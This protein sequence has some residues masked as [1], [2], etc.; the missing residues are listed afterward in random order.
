MLVL[1]LKENRNDASGGQGRC[2]WTSPGGIIPPDPFVVGDSRWCRGG[3]WGVNGLAV[4]H[5]GD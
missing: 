5:G 1:L 2:P 4:G 3:G